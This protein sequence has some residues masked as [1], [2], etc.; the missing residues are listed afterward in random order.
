MATKSE[1]LEAIRDARTAFKDAIY[2]KDVRQGLVDVADSVYDA[3]DQWGVLIDGTLTQSGQAADAAAVGNRSVLIRTL[4]D[5]TDEGVTEE[6]SFAW[7]TSDAL[8]INGI[9][10]P[11]CY[12]ILAT[13]ET[14]LYHTIL[15]LPDDLQ[16]DGCYLLVERYYAGQ[17]LGT[18]SSMIR[19]TA[20]SLLSGS[21]QPTKMYMRTRGP[22]TV[23]WSPW[24]AIADSTD[25]AAVN[26]LKT[27]TYNLCTD[28]NVSLRSWNLRSSSDEAVIVVNNQTRSIVMKLESNTT[29]A[30]SC[31]SKGTRFSVGYFKT[32]ADMPSVGATGLFIYSTQTGE[33]EYK[34]A[35][36]TT[37]NDASINHFVVVYYWIISDTIPEDEIRRAIMIT[38]GAD[39]KEYRL[40]ED[41]KDIPQGALPPPKYGVFGVKFNRDKSDPIMLRTCDA[42]GM[43]YR[44]QTGDTVEYSDFDNVFPWCDMHECNIVFDEH[45]NKTAVVYKGESGFSRADDTYIEVPMFYFRR[46]VVAGVEEWEISGQPFSGA[47]VEPWFVNADGSIAKCRY[48][49]KY[50]GADPATGKVSI[51]NVYPKTSINISECRAHCESQ[52]AKLMSIQARL[53]L[54]HLMVI[55]LGTFDAQ[56]VNS[57]I[58]WFLFS[59]ITN[60]TRILNKSGRTVTLRNVSSGNYMSGRNDNIMVGDTVY[61][62]SSTSGTNNPRSV[63]SKNLNGDNIELTLDADIPADA[64]YCYAAKQK[65]GSTDGMSYGN[66]R[67]N[68]QNKTRPFLYRG[69]ENLFGNVWE[70]VDGIIWN[71]STRKYVIDSVET[72]YTEHFPTPLDGESQ[73]GS[74]MKAKGF[75]RTL[76]YD[77]DMPWATMP[78]YV[79]GTADPSNAHKYVTD[80]WDPRSENDG[81]IICVSG[82]WDHEGANGIL[83]FR[84][85]S[86]TTSNWLYGYRAMV[87]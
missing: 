69:L 74:D 59:T 82:G 45:G 35:K 37:D 3:V 62:S 17:N 68:A 79:I 28:D 19:Q 26:E 30:V 15:N 66:G 67:T 80:E 84:T 78:E 36:F 85:L 56:A 13:S 24:T 21:T 48:I 12:R 27:N 57:G 58:S 32:A 5:V 71:F 29:Y 60:F 75:I 1:I 38:K 6:N 81:Q 8:N 54:A 53:A 16:N 4:D 49:A 63:V 52:N 40:P 18:I 25:I 7:N 77:R 73:S 2:G 76:G 23:A 50:E 14:Y 61:L 47:N 11:G 72:S 51:T 22:S 44:Q 20:F 86:P 34:Y 65:T 43:E 10:I 9:R 41:I 70:F 31:A 55:E 39:Y 42:V 46:R 83:N 33:P 87:D 64:I